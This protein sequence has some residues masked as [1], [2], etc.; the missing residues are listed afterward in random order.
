[1]A[2]SGKMSNI[3]GQKK[4]DLREVEE[5]TAQYFDKA[6]S[7]DKGF[8]LA[9]TGLKAFLASKGLSFLS[10]L[11]DPMAEEAKDIFN[12]RPSK[13]GIE[14]SVGTWSYGLPEEIV[15]GIT[16]GEKDIKKTMWQSTFAD[17]LSDFKSSNL[18]LDLGFG[19][20]GEETNIFNELFS[21]GGRVPKYKN[22]GIPTI[23]D[24]FVLQNK[25]L[26]G[27]NIKSMR[28]K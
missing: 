27:S 10:P 8:G 24:Y 7:L 11:V 20:T 12:L 13:E 19:D 23:V 4:S 15:K 26:G 28:G 9:K 1:M 21:E 16:S 14:R 5:A 17:Y 18:G 3:W 6:G 22:G 25:T 2:L